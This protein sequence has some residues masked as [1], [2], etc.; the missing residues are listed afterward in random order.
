[1]EAPD[2]VAGSGLLGAGD[3]DVARRH[4]SG[5]EHFAEGDDEVALPDGVGV[6]VGRGAVE[7]AG[8][9]SAG[10]GDGLRVGDAGDSQEDGPMGV[11]DLSEELLVRSGRRLRTSDW[12]RRGLRWR[13][14]I[15]RR[16]LGSHHL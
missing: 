16:S 4:A 9:D 8:R 3:V 10:H 11:G 15:G 12:L 1:G 2:D 7:A 14:S 13:T 6:G 5:G